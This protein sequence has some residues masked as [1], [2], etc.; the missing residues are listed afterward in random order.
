[1]RNLGEWAK[2]RSC[3]CSKLF[4]NPTIKKMSK[5]EFKHFPV[6]KEIEGI[7]F[8]FQTSVLKRI[9]RNIA[10]FCRGKCQYATNWNKNSFLKRI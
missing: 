7:I 9:P 3:Y 1:M 5:M 10:F 4:V 6:L 2:T 8:I